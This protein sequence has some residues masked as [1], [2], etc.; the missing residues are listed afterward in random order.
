MF[1]VLS[2][3][4]LFACPSLFLFEFREFVE[5]AVDQVNCLNFKLVFTLFNFV[6]LVS[7]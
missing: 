2:S 1:F 5:T 3:G 6:N 7:Q 4:T